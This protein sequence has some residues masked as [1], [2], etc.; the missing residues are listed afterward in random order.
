MIYVLPVDEWG[1]GYYRLIWPVQVLKAHGCDIKIIQP[2]KHRFFINPNGGIMVPP[3]TELVVIQRPASVFHVKLIE[4]LRKVGIA[5]V[6][7]MDDDVTCIDPSN[8]AYG[9]YRHNDDKI[10]SWRYAVESCRAA[11]FITT[12]TASLLD[13]YDAR[14]RG[15]V[16]DNYIPAAYL[17]LP[18]HDVKTFGWAGNTLSHYRDLN[19]MTP[20]TQQLIDEGHEFRVVGGDQKTQAALRLRE[21]PYMTGGVPVIRWAQTIS[22]NIGVGLVPLEPT[23]FNRGKSRLKCIEY[24]AVGVPWVGSPREEYRKLNKESGCGFMADA[25][26]QWYTMVKNLLVDEVLHREQAE[27]GREYV[28]TQTYELNAWRWAEAWQ[29]AI[30]RQGQS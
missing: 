28:K 24:M 30:D 16:L 21:R 6:I 29:A 2:S 3:D 25:P 10:H 12:S 1:C 13:V 8:F 7:D 17:D 20:C 26:K 11:T 14:R 19:E 18:Q 27:M 4:A 5:V 22:E 9:Y 23:R 15:A